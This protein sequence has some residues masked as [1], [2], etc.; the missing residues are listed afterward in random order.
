LILL[1]RRWL[2]ARGWW[3]GRTVAVL[4]ALAATA[5]LGGCCA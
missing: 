2:L 5:V 4:G 1:R 3:N